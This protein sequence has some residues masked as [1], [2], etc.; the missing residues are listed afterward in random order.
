MKNIHRLRL[1]I[2]LILLSWFPFAQIVIYIAHSNGNLTSDKNAQLVRLIIWLIQ[3]AVGLIGVWL[4][5]PIAIQTAKQAGWRQ[6]PKKLWLL[7]RNAQEK[8]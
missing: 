6:T 4:A 3:I 2:I 7:F 8:S 5:G 1:G